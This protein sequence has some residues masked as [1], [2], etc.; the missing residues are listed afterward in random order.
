MHSKGFTIVELLVSAAIVIGVMG[1]ALVVVGQ[2]RDA[3]DRD[4]MGIESAQRLRAGLEALVH[5]VRTAGAGPEADTT[6]VSLGHAVPVV[7]FLRPAGVGAAAG[8]RFQ[9][10]RVMSAPREA[11]HG[12]LADPGGGAALRLAPPPACPALPA[13]GFQQGMTVAVYDGSGVFDLATVQAVD[14]PSSAITVHPPVGRTYPAGSIVSEVAV[15]TFDVDVAADGS[16]RLMRNTSGAAQPIVDA[17]VAFTVE[18]FGDAIPPLPGRGPRS[19]PTYGPVP[20]LPGVD[21]PRDAWA[22]GE[23]CTMTIGADGLAAPRLPAWGD[24]GAQIALGPSRLDD[25]PWCPAAGGG[26]YDADL[27]RLRRVDLRLRVESAAAHLRGPA[28]T[29]FTRGG[30]GRPTSWVPDLELRV[31]LTLANIARR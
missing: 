3:L 1:V 6:S 10:L 8:E 7:E 22:A 31:S 12:R 13:C 21:D 5:D 11:A 28:G 19:P 9:A 16:G 26:V 30:H 24:A 27:Y 25:G 15:S 2:A 4:G 20:P 23:N 29:I 17:V 18:A 14:A